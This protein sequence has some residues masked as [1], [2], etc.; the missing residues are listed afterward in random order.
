MNI[1]LLTSLLSADIC[2]F[3]DLTVTSDTAIKIPRVTCECGTVS[4][5]I[6]SKMQ[7]NFRDIKM[8]IKCTSIK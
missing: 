3:L 6:E 7:L 1:S 8:C 5:F 2:A 4:Y